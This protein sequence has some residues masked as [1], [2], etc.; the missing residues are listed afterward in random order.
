[1]AGKIPLETARRLAEQVIK[2]LS[3]YCKKKT[4]GRTP[5][6]EIA[7]SVRRRKPQVKDIEVLLIPVASWEFNTE[8]KSLGHINKGGSKYV[9]VDMGM[10]NLDLF[11]ATEETWGTLLLIRTGSAENNIRL[12]TRAKDMGWHLHA[13][14]SG[15]F[16][17]EG[18]RIAGDTEQSIYNALGL[19]YKR[20]EER[21]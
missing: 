16:N 11:F 4:D 21:G 7:G 8:I 5:Y 12:C 18:R 20:P 6:I 10:C 9:Q 2:R 3:P 17:A 1:M 15:L 13:D 14:G 19:P